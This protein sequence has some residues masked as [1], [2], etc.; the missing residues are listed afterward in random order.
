M[1]AISVAAILAAL[2]TPAIS[3]D[4]TPSA[5]RALLEEQGGASLSQP[6][7]Q[8]ALAAFLA[9]VESGDR[10]WIDLVPLLAARVDEGLS[11]SLTA[12]LSEALRTNPQG[13]L[14]V[15][16]TSHYQADDVCADR[17]PDASVFD[18]VQF[19][20]EALVKVAAVL[21]P[22]LADTRNAC[23]YSLTDARIAALI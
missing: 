18:T 4:M 3:I 6:I 2:T 11:Q 14:S 22:A 20:D 15:M 5:W 17:S 16:A 1:R 7:D 23:L 21:D 12:T 10:G 19:I 8:T 13:V 9:H